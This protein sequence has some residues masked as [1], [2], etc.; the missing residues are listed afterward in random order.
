MDKQK[1]ERTK[2]ANVGIVITRV[3]FVLA[4]ATVLL[5]NI[6]A[7]GPKNSIHNFIFRLRNF[8]LS[9]DEK[10]RLSVGKAFYDFTLF[11][12]ENT[13]EDSVIL[14]PPQAYPWPQTGNAG[15]L[16]YFIFPRKVIN[17]KEFEPGINLAENRIEYV[18]FLQSDDLQTPGDV[19]TPGWPKFDLRAVYKLYLLEDGNTKKVPGNYNQKEIRENKNLR[20]I[21]KLQN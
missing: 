19:L 15:Y 21:I 9:Y 11:I 1:K 5:L 17:G 14:I 18:L 2:S 10:M 3:I 4:T 13:P 7:I 12:R 16:R 20:G 8:N 6:D